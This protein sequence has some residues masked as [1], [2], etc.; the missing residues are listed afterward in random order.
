MVENTIMTVVKKIHMA[1]IF[2]MLLDYVWVKFFLFTMQDIFRVFLRK[3]SIL[4]TNT[5]F[6]C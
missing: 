4:R 3:I 5:I 2:Y 1:I 6:S